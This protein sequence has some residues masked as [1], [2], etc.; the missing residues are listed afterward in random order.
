MGDSFIFQ[1]VP[2]EEFKQ[3]CKEC[4]IEI[5]DNLCLQVWKEIK[6][7]QRATKFSAGYDFFCPLPITVKPNEVRL[8]PTG[9]R[10]VASNQNLCMILLPRSSMGFKY[11]MKL[12]NTVGLIDADYH[13]SDNYGHIMAKISS[14][15]SCIITK[16]KAFMQGV[17]LPYYISEFDETSLE[18]RNGGFGSTDGAK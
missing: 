9:I 2:F 11:G 6:L 17:I 12:M 18:S 3:S 8:I 10:W 7:P 4:N 1:K 15:S 5:E 14:E 16:G 13:L